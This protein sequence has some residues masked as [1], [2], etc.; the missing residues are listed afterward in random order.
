M[1]A[2]K[3]PHGYRTLL[4]AGRRDA[5][6]G[7]SWL[8]A[9]C[10]QRIDLSS[11]ELPLIASNR[12]AARAVLAVSRQFAAFGPIGFVIA[13]VFKSLFGIFLAGALK[14]EGM[15]CQARHAPPSRP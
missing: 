13:Q 8:L 6:E 12:D 15:Q 2:E 14:Q 10:M 9:P 11:P 7:G 5:A 3:V 1:N 4:E